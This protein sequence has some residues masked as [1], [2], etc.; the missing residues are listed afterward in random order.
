[1]PETASLNRE[2]LSTGDANTTAANRF[3]R[4]AGLDLSLTAT[5][6]CDEDV[7]PLVIST[8]Y[9][10]MPRV[11]LVL[12]E[13]ERHLAKHHVDLV[14]IEGYSYGSKGAAVYGIAELGGVVRHHLWT[15]GTPYV[16]VPPASLKK[17]ACG[18]RKS[19]DKDAMVATAARLGCPADNNNA[20][21]AW[22][23]L[24]LGLYWLARDT[25]VVPRAGYRD[26]ALSKVPW[27]AADSLE[28]AL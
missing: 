11:E 27:P 21:D 12:H 2:S 19:R 17:F 15:T 3:T 9:T 16:D 18:D 28:S 13:I 20:C 26:D 10:G 8:R 25:C 7:E 14:V 1:M 23:L 24:Q 5:G 6:Y 4:L 22:W